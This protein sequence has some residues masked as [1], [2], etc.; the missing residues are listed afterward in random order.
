MIVVA[1]D[2]N[3]I[4]LQQRAKEI[5]ASAAISPVVLAIPDPHIERWLLLDGAAFKSVFGKGC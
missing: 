1:T 5:E 4:G 3:C 2:A